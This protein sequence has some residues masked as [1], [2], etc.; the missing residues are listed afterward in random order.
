M[1]KVKVNIVMENSEIY[2]A[3]SFSKF[4]LYGRSQIQHN[5]PEVA[6]LGNISA[7]LKCCMYFCKTDLVLM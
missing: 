4:C 1:E 6:L 2:L 5:G 3:L 7:S